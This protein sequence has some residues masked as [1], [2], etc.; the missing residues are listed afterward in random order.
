MERAD[1]ILALRR[2]DAGLAADGGIDLRKQR[3]RDLHEAHAAAEDARGKAG[4]VADHAAAERDDGVAAL[5]AKLQ[6]SLAEPG[7]HWEA[8]A[9]LAWRHHRLAKIDAVAASSDLQ[10]TPR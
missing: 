10:R 4:K 3:R 7:E 6:Q 1:Q 9:C 2:V 8:L 5:N